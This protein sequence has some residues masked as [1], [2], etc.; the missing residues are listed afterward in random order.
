MICPI[1]D[2]HKWRPRKWTPPITDHP[3]S[4]HVIADQQTII[5]LTIRGADLVARSAFRSGHSK[6]GAGGVIAGEWLALELRSGRLRMGIRSRSIS[7]VNL[8]VSE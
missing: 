6:F 7:S 8:V 3:R 5:D 2:H 4:A 1:T